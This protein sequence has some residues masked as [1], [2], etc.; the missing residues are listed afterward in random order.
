MMRQFQVFMAGDADKDG[1]V[2]LGD[3]ALF[4]DCMAGPQAGP[5]PPPPGTA[6]ECLN[7][8]DT[9]IDG[10]VDLKDYAEFSIVFTAP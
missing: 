1:D 3:W 2:D 9:E 8:F 10:D 6:D 4:P 7:D 5:T